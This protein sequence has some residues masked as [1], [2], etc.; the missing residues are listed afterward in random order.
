MSYVELRTYEIDDG[1]M[2]AFLAWFHG[3]IPIREQYGYRILFA[4]ADRSNN[5]FTWAVEHSEP[6]DLAQAIYDAAPERAKY[7]ESNPGVVSSGTSAEV[8]VIVPFGT[9]VGPQ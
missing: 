2:D 3:L 7:F 8:E 4:Y 6:L 5:R 1:E 9:Q